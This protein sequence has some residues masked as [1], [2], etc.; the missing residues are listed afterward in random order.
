[1]P[2]PE[3][4]GEN[5]PDFVCE[6]QNIS[7]R[8]PINHEVPSIDEIQTHLH[9]LKSGK[10]SNDVDPELLKRCEHP[11]MLTVIH[12][13]ASNLW[14][15]LDMP[16]AWG[17]SRLK[18]LW[19]G[20]GSKSD[21]SRYRGLSI[22]STLC[23][24]IINIILE[25]I[26]PWYE[27]Q[28]SEEQ[29]GFRKNRGT[30]DGIYSLKRAHQILN[31]KKQPLFLLFVDLTAAFD[32]I[33]RKYLFDS[34]RLR[35]P[36]G[37]TAKLF[38]I[39]EFLYQK[40][41]LT[42]QEAQTSFLVTS[43]VRQG[44]PESPLL[45]N[46]YIDFVMRVFMNRCIQDSSIHFFKHQY[47]INTRSI[48]R[49]Q[50]L[51]MRNENI[52]SWGRSS[53]PWCGY[54]DDLILFM[55]NVHSLQKATTTLDEVFRS[56]GL[57]INETKTET[58][59]LNQL[60]LE[61]EYPDSIINLRNVALQNSSEFKYLGSYISRNEPNT[62]DIE[63]NHCIQMA[64]VKFASMTNLLHNQNIYLK[65][66]IKFLN[67]FIRSRL[68]YSCQNWNFTTGQSERLNLKYRN[69][70]R[71][72]VRG[73]FKRI[74]DNDDDFHYKLSNDKIHSICC[75]SDVSNFVREQQRN[76]ASHVVRM[77]IERCAKQLMFNDD[78]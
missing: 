9:R 28:L 66:R 75:T 52:K 3:E 45:F 32:H 53:F 43:G 73:G 56:Y 74:G 30:T 59:I 29:N 62:G 63:V 17:N 21:P 1:M 51:I 47:R 42:Y 54:A 18:T 61:G 10:A 31:R 6:L 8:F 64:N 14:E 5:L 35:V 22:G 7:G 27:A 12:R 36:E 44:G 4:F 46:L 57:C 24:L 15:N 68:V 55:L 23:K 37:E 20:K 2:L 34:I 72:M 70:L 26:R 16:A 38:K 60:F 41:S 19:K 49:E 13:K 48:S 33:P 67:S 11:V 69:F 65:T 58:M 71:R 39:L 76:Y 40:T 77:P 78:Q 25:R 50:R